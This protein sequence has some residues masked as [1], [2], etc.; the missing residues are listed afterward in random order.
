M[1]A[2]APPAELPKKTKVVE[3]VKSICKSHIP[4]PLAP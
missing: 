3:G 1:K 4:M 2:Q